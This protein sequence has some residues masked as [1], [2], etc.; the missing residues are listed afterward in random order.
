MATASEIGPKYSGSDAIII[1]GATVLRSNVLNVIATG[2]WATVTSSRRS[3]SLGR[4]KSYL[5][6]GLCPSDWFHSREEQGLISQSTT[7]YESYDVP[8]DLFTALTNFE[9]SVSKDEVGL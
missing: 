8:I 9:E 5:D 4:R 6:K 3:W 2:S 7:S 1:P